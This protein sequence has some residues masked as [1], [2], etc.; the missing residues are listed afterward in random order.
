MPPKRARS[1][2]FA[3][4]ATTPICGPCQNNE[5][6]AMPDARL[7]SSRR[8]ILALYAAG[9]VCSGGREA[10]WQFVLA[11]K[12]LR[13]MVVCKAVTKLPRHQRNALSTKTTGR[14]PTSN[15]VQIHRSIIDKKKEKKDN[16]KRSVYRQL[17]QKYIFGAKRNKF[18]EA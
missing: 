11:T 7:C 1:A 13:A 8:M 4:R 5:A 16:E 17:N 10:E 3:L 6:Q 15:E 18:P 9:V 2:R 14:L 12:A